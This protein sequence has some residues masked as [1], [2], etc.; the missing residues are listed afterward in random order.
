MKKF[1]LVFSVFLLSLSLVACNKNLE[2]PK[3]D[4][5]DHVELTNEEY[6]HMISNFTI[7]QDK[8]I[9]FKYYQET[10]DETSDIVFDISGK[11]N[12]TG[13][14]LS[15]K[16]KGSYKLFEQLTIVDYVYDLY[17]T[18]DK[19]YIN[20]K[21]ID[22]QSSITNM[23]I[24]PGKYIV[25]EDSILNGLDYVNTELDAISF[26]DLF[27]SETIKSYGTYKGLKV[28][29]KDKDTFIQLNITQENG[30]PEINEEIIDIDLGYSA[31]GNAEVIFVFENNRF[32]KLAGKVYGKTLD[33]TNYTEVIYELT[34]NKIDFPDFSSYKKFSLN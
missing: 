4:S 7:E 14:I 18:K 19:T 13:L 20:V 11:I 30:I 25:T 10:K 26:S 8:T 34:N 5:N 24:K 12:E 21:K 6:E 27:N 31:L 33:N 23:N 22:T 17:I 28:Y 3:V 32:T 9:E 2:F 16:I 15:V 1:F 29:Q